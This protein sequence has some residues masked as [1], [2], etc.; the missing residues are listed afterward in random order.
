MHSDRVTPADP[1][2]RRAL[3]AALCAGLASFNALYA[4]QAILPAL[5]DSF[6]VSPTITALTVSA[7]TGALALTVLPAGVVSERFGRRRVIQVSALAA[8]ALSLLLCCMP[9]IQAIIGLRFLQGI[10]V[11]GV[12]AV[13]MTYL[14]E[15]IDGRY[16]PRVM[17][18]YI[19]GTTLGGLLG[20]LIPGIALDFMGWRQ[21]VL[22]SAVFAVAMAIITATVIPPQ[23]TFQP[24]AITW[25]HELSAISGHLHNPVLLRLFALPFLLM[26]VFVSLYN[27]LSFRL[28]ESF[29]LPASL[30][31]LTFVM[32]LSGTW[33]SARAGALVS[34]WGRARVVASSSLLAAVGLAVLFIPT[35]PSTL[36]GSLLF[37]AAFFAAHSA[38]SAWVGKIA[39]HDRAEA[40]S[41]YV[42]SYYLGSSL[43][44]WFSGYF[45][46]AGWAVFVTW[47]VVV[48]S[49]SFLIALS[50]SK[51]GNTRKSGS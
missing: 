8:T 15:E 18:F 20:R 48:V 22:L 11:A 23:R 38:A 36:L 25:R 51:Q 19:S 44:G 28:I 26:G 9:S 12:P 7:T 49:V 39:T 34:K 50:L 27:Y 10:A 24:K 32:Y 29:G 16:L 37:T 3:I 4:T 1:R 5:S 14:A 35:L 47:I 13:V 6:Q 45:F 46:H 31:A 42:F 2:Y 30:A 33:S 41:L 43:M 21:A 17:G 40:S